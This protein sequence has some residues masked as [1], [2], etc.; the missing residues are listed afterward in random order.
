MLRRCPLVLRIIV[1]L[2]ERC[3]APRGVGRAGICLIAAISSDGAPN[4]IEEAVL[5]R[6]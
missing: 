2:M 5:A 6:K 4:G 3:L 1:A